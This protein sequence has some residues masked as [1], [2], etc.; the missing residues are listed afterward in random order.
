ME[1]RRCKLCNGTGYAP[2]IRGNT[3]FMSLCPR[4]KGTGN[5][6]MEE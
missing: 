3:S 1:V 4:C 5:E 6:P 2:V